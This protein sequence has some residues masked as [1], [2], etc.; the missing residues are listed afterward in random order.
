MP[1]YVDGKPF[2]GSG[3][4][5]VRDPHNPDSV[6]HSVSTITPDD[7][8]KVMAVARAAGKTWK[9]VRSVA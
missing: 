6:L 7:V 2:T 5:D 8:P 9:K 3:K 4:F 1:C